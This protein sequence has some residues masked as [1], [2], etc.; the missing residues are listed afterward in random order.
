[1]MAF[2]PVHP[3]ALPAADRP[4]LAKRRALAVLLVFVAAGIF[5]FAVDPAGARYL[6]ECPSRLAGAYCPG[7]GTLRATH[8]LFHGRVLAALS[9]N[10]L[11]LLVL[12]VLGFTLIRQ[13]WRIA[14]DQPAAP[15][16]SGLRPGW[17]WGLFALICVY[18]VARN[19]PWYPFTLLG[20]G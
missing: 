3:P 11:Y 10:P 7:C 5:L 20:P 17:I 18:T 15:I 13:G 16:G 4:R 6:P 8:A 1:M 14:R 2:S 9:L 12:P 19:L